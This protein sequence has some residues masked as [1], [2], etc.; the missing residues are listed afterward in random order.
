MATHGRTSI[1]THPVATTTARIVL[2][3]S[4]PA[5]RPKRPDLGRARCAGDDPLFDGVKMEEE[6][7]KVFA[8]KNHSDM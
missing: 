1:T 5:E 2:S 3:S 6:K 4:R 7:Q 8:R